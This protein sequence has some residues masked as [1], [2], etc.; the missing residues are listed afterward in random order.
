MS[1]PVFQTEETM[2][3]NRDSPFPVTTAIDACKKLCM[4][5]QNSA[6]FSLNAASRNL[7]VTSRRNFILV[8]SIAMHEKEN[9]LITR[10]L[11]TQSPNAI[12]GH[13][14]LFNEVWLEFSRYW[15]PRLGNGFEDSAWIL[16]YPPLLQSWNSAVV[17][18]I[19]QLHLAIFQSMAK[20]SL[21]RYLIIMTMQ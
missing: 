18:S 15:K 7:A 19:L 11:F 13:V 17:F 8:N 2:N 9:P 16:N 20:Q 3:R 4:T 14:S 21:I 1:T 12:L 5:M 6:W 10:G